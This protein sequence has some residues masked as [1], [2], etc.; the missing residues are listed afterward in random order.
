MWKLRAL[1][2]RLR[3]AYGQ[4][5]RLIR[6]I[7]QEHFWYLRLRG[8]LLGVF[9]WSEEGW[10]SN[11]DNYEPN[12]T[13][14]CKILNLGPLEPFGLFQV[15]KATRTTNLRPA[16]HT[17]DLLKSFAFVQKNNNLCDLRITSEWTQQVWAISCSCL[18]LSDYLCP[19]EHFNAILDKH[20][21]S[22]H[23]LG[24]LKRQKNVATLETQSVTRRHALF[25][26]LRKLFERLLFL[27]GFGIETAGSQTGPFFK[28]SGA[29]FISS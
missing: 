6:G 19:V 4:E 27:F 26:I 18:D 21:K 1:A 13:Q 23:T 7:F 15:E 25:V 22:V 11:Y 12:S 24:Q 2:G 9:H 17:T 29:N 28:S 16:T 5:P 3:Y 8:Y 14:P 20:P 10:A